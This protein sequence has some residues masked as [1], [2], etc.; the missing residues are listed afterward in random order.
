MNTTSNLSVNHHFCAIISPYPIKQIWKYLHVFDQ[1][2]QEFH[3]SNFGVVNS[4]GKK[5]INFSPLRLVIQKNYDPE[6]S[7]FKVHSFRALRRYVNDKNSIHGRG[8]A[9]VFQFSTRSF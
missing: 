8:T 2:Q 4:L 1:Q 3:F 6:T 7:E 9:S 5:L